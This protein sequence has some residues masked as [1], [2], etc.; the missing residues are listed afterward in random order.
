MKKQ[1][2][3]YPWDILDEG[4]RPLAERLATMGIDTAVLALVYHSGKLLLPHNPRRRV[5]MHGSSRCY[6]PFLTERYG[7][8]KPL[9]GELLKEDAAGFLNRVQEGFRSYGIRVCAWAVVFH[10]GR[11]ACA[12]PELAEQN[13]WGEPSAHSLCPSQ[14]EVF[15]YGLTLLEDIA[16]TGVEGLYLESVDYGGFVHGAH[17]EMQAFAD[18]R[19]LDLLLG[20][21]FCPACTQQ[22]RQAGIDIARLHCEVRGQTERLFACAPVQELPSEW[23]AWK[24]V[25]ARRVADFYAALRARLDARGLNT[26]V[27]PILWMSDGADPYDAGID[28]MLLAPYVDS[29]AALYP[30]SPEQ[31]PAFVARTKT[32]IPLQIPLICGVRLMAPHTLFARQTAEYLDAYRAEGV[33]QMVFYNYGMA[34]LPFLEALCAWKEEKEKK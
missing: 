12:Y 9:T 34:P 28:P 13:A 21:C 4:V 1:I 33:R 14:E 16:A 3:L 6:F 11:L 30:E 32:L 19:R 18:T 5:L 23:P 17:H 8:L 10:A 22:A 25:R 24:A 31:V 29:F 2:F 15:A 20:Q 7:R 27:T 26:A